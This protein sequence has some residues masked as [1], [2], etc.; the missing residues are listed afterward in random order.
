MSAILGIGHVSACGTGIGDLRE[1][2]AGRRFP[3]CEEQ[4]IRTPRGQTTV[5]S[6]PARIAGLER[7]ASSRQLRRI[8]RFAQMALLACGLAIEDAGQEIA[9]VVKAQRLGLVFAT[10]HGPLG[11]TFG[12]Q[13]GIL[14]G[15]DREASPALFTNSVHNM[16]ASHV[17]IVLGLA[18]PSLT[19]SALEFG[20]A[21]AVATAQRWIERG[22]VDAVLVGFGEE[23]CPLVLYAAACLCAQTG[24]D[25]ASSEPSAACAYEPGEGF[26]AIL[27]GKPDAAAAR[28]VEIE[29]V[30]LFA[31]LHETRGALGP[32]RMVL[33]ATGVGGPGARARRLIEDVPARR[34]LTPLRGDWATGQG[35]DLAAAAL[36]LRDGRTVAAGAM[37]GPNSGIA[38]SSVVLPA[39]A[40]VA[41]VQCGA[42]G[43][44]AVMISRS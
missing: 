27:L 32:A 1:V 20:P 6:H 26:M 14:E 43:G 30:R 11:A 19:L 8:D 3:A 7:F 40:Q 15:G 35:F 13:D 5:R 34:S 2:L 44:A 29:G 33:F 23:L 21:M 31:E 28:A 25:P 4:T 38:D 22:E 17:S 36:M 18:A 16:A 12:F 24:E 37:E 9:E 42:E 10:G 39:G 41:C